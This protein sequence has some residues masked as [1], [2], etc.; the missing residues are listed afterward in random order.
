MLRRSAKTMITT[1]GIVGVLGVGVAVAADQP[2]CP[3]GNTPKVTQTQT[4]TQQRLR[5]GTGPRHTTRSQQRGG[6]G[7][8][9]H[10]GAG[11]GPRNGSGNPTCPNRE[12]ALARVVA[13]ADRGRPAMAAHRIEPCRRWS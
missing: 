6:Q 9:R 2:T 3:Y 5:D 1:A 12:L 4:G 8:G 13:P 10:Q 7:Q 11:N